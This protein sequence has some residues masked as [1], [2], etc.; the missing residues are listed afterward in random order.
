[1]SKREKALARF[2]NN[3]KNVRYEELEAVLLYLGFEKRQ[4]G[5]SHVVFSIPGSSPITIPV[6]KPFLKPIYVELAIHAIDE[7]N[8]DEGEQE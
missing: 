2:R 3:P 4:K 6:R 7:L 5:T 1:M 8:F